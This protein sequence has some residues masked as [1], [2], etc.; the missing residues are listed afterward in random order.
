MSLLSLEDTVQL[1]EILNDKLNEHEHPDKATELFFYISTDG[2]DVTV[3]FDQL[4]VFDDNSSWSDD[5]ETGYPYPVIML[6]TIRRELYK[7]MDEIESAV[8]VVENVIGEYDR[9]ERNS[10]GT[11]TS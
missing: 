8:N 2:Y 10:L 3:S 9:N 7:Y 6:R 1:V 4:S 5:E 11:K